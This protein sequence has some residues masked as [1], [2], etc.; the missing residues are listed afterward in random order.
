L[1]QEAHLYC[2]EI[3]QYDD[4]AQKHLNKDSAIILKKLTSNLNNLDA[5]NHDNIE[6]ACRDTATEL[7]EGK[8]GKV[9]MPLR[10]ALTGTDKSPAL[11]EAAEVLGLEETRKRIQNAI[12]FIEK[13]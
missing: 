1:A 6:Q 12:D 4:K 8:L 9:M 5:F 11:Y 7:A 2:S 3:E 13:S 10:A